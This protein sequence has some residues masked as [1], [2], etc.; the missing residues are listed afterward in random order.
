MKGKRQV[1]IFV[2]DFFQITS[3]SK[4]FPQKGASPLTVAY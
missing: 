4:V 2:E 1:V 3:L